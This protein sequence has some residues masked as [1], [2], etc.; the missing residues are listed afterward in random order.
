MI[1]RI[2]WALA[3]A[4]LAV[5]ACFAQLDRAARSQSQL[6]AAVP[7]MFRGFAAERLTQMSL[8]ARDGPAANSEARLLIAAR[9]LPAEHLRLLSQAA[10]LEED[11]PRSLAALEAASMRGWRDPV[12]QLAAAQAALLQRQPEAAAQRIAALFAT[13][14]FLDETPALAAQ[15][16]AEP[17]G[18]AAFARQLANPAR[19]PGNAIAPLAG[20]VPPAQLAQTLALASEFGADLPCDRL[21]AIAQRYRNERHEQAAALFWPGDCPPDNDG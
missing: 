19:W 6:A 18:Q 5:I 11:T 7:A 10:A 9:P 1:G 4:A 17:A 13:G 2:V 15:L 8:A 3:L 12:A 20:A 21:A 14:A 16:L